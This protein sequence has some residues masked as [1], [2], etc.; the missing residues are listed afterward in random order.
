MDK[1]RAI[2]LDKN[3]FTGTEIANVLKVTP[4][5]IHA[6]LVESLTDPVRKEIIDDR[7]LKNEFTRIHKRLPDVDLKKIIYFFNITK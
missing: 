7:W 5:R 6:V 4:Q 1:D 3:Y 2:D